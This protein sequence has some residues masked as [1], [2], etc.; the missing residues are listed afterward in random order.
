[1]DAIDGFTA[2]LEHRTL[3]D[4]SAV[5]VLASRSGFSAHSAHIPNWI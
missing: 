2:C 3:G 5:E 4:G 1:M